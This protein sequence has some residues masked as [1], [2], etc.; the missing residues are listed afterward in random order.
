MNNNWGMTIRLFKK[1]YPIIILILACNI[2]DPVEQQLPDHIT[3]NSSQLPLTPQNTVLLLTN[4]STGKVE[5]PL[6]TMNSN[7]IRSTTS[8][9]REYIPQRRLDKPPRR[10][11]PITSREIRDVDPIRVYQTGDTESFVVLTESNP[12][13]VYNSVEL[14]LE[15]IAEVPGNIYSLNIWVDKSD[16]ENQSYP[17]EAIAHLADSF[18]GIIKDMNTI[19]GAPWG[20][21]GGI[22]DSYIS[23]NRTDIHILLLDIA[24][25][26]GDTIQA[27]SGVIYGYFDSYDLYRNDSLSEETKINSG[28]SNQC[29]NLVIDSYLYFNRTKDS[30]DNVPEWSEYN[31]DSIYGISTLIHELQHMIHFYQ[32]SILKHQDISSNEAIFVNEMF[33]M[34]AEDILASKYLKVYLGSGIYGYI[35][36]DLDRIPYFNTG[37]DIQGSYQWD[38][39]SLQSYANAYTLGAYLIRNYN[40]ELLRSYLTA[41]SSGVDGLITTLQSYGSPELNRA[42][43]LHNFGIAVLKSSSTTTVFPYI[44]NQDIELLNGLYFLFAFDLHSSYYY[45]DATFTTYSF[46]KYQDISTTPFNMESNFYIDL[47]LV[48][49]NS[50]IQLKFNQGSNDIIYSLV[51]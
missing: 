40:V 43:L 34:V 9:K 42:T 20:S 28:I 30:E 37:W 29:L 1:I 11:E 51:F 23:E 41:S 47:G 46:Q 12:Y 10:A 38:N 15:H 19:Y 31:L 14:T 8:K 44:F 32:K 36:P 21:R 49:Q 18:S 35:P 16:P 24:G 2:N 7:S 6:I 48:D 26:G 4:K 45:G 13:S 17:G 50:I 22:S 3:L 25:D 5:L 33:S 27:D 39:N